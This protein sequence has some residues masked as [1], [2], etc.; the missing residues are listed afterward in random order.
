MATLK[1]R[2]LLLYIFCFAVLVLTQF[3][4]GALLA[5]FL[6][7][8]LAL[9]LWKKNYN[10]KNQIHYAI[11]FIFLIPGLLIW[12]A[13]NSFFESYSHQ[14]HLLFSIAYGFLSFSFCFIYTLLTVFNY[15]FTQPE[16]SI[17]QV[18]RTCFQK[19]KTHRFI[20]FYVSLI[21]FLMTIVRYFLPVDYK[22][23]VGIIT[24]HLFLQQDELFKIIKK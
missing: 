3:P 15:A 22:I 5:L 20:I 10:L 6:W 8:Q 18:Y 16:S 9:L 23:V 12:G 2:H 17:T 11:H 4:G 1:L 19:I 7:M 13:V 21:I 14:N 24:A